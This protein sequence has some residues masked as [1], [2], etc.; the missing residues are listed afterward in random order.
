LLAGIR[1]RLT[2]A[3]VISTLCL[4]LLLGGGAYAVSTA[5]RN[6]VVSKSIK[7]DQVKSPDVKD[8]GL[9]GA[10]IQESSLGPDEFAA[11]PNARVQGPDRRTEVGGACPA[12]YNFANNV[13]APLV[14]EDLISQDGGLW[15]PPDPDN[16][17][18]C[19]QGSTLTATRDGLYEVSAGLIWAANTNGSRQLILKRDGLD[20]LAAERAAASPSGET[21]QNVST[22][23]RLQAGDFMQATAFQDSGATLSLAAAGDPRN[24]FAMDWV[25]P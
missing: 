11:V 2:Y 9:T 19:D 12:T 13:E 21:I 5:P 23:T 14:W 8:N 16:L 15:S 18:P 10:D 25:G 1:S 6:S 17:P 7:N 20:Y 3:N 4:F 24:F 22:L